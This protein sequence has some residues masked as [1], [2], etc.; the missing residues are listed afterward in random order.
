MDNNVD[1]VI[2]DFACLYAFIYGSIGNNKKS[3]NE[4]EKRSTIKWK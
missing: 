4:N 3:F 1:N 2:K